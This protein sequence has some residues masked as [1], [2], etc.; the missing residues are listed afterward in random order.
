MNHWISVAVQT[1]AHSSVAG[2]L[3]YR[4]ELPLPPGTLV[5]APLGSREVLGIVWSPADGPLDGRAAEATRAIAGALEGIEPLSAPWLELVAFAAGYYQRALG[6]LALAALPPQLR[7]LSSTQLARRLKAGAGK[8]RDVSAGNAAG[9]SPDFIALS[10][11][12]TLALAEFESKP[13][14]FLLFGATGSGK[15]EVYLHAVAALLERDPGAQALVM[16]PEINLT[17]QLEARF[18]RALWRRR[19]G[20]AAQRHDPPA[21]P[22]E[23]AGRAQ[24]RRA[25]RAGHAHGG[26]CVH[27]RPG[28]IV[29]DE[30][31]DPSYKQQEGARY[32]AR[33]LA[34]YR[35]RLDGAKVLL[36][37]ATP[38]LESW[39]HRPPPTTPAA[40]SAW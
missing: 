24:R 22:E 1:P 27:A 11:Q 26:V 18:Q 29:V 16:V 35:G 38:S 13:G 9:K 5:R 28:L 4:S 7:E 36:G 14:P 25:H 39:H 10:D 3:T 31:H 17:P 8:P 21:A 40:T 15:T 32:S 33:D 23:L 19:R 6:E 30:E 2:P 12:Q 37:S 34:V 20:L